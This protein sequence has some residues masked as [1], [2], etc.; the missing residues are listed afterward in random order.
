MKQGSSRITSSYYSLITNKNYLQVGTRKMDFNGKRKNKHFCVI[1]QL[2]IW[3]EEDGYYVLVSRDINKCFYALIRD[4]YQKP[5]LHIDLV[6]EADDKSDDE[7]T[8][9]ETKDKG[10]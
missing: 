8:S 7:A 3:K 10:G 2:L 1:R 4:T 5:E 6:Q 9:F